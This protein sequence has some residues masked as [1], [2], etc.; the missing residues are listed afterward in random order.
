MNKIIN[1]HA[2]FQKEYIFVVNEATDSE[3]KDTFSDI[4]AEELMIQAFNNIEYE[5]EW[6]T[7]E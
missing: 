1:S 6:S 5:E 7:G 2:D 4:I 3:I